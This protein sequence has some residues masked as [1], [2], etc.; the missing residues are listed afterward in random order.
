MM[1]YLVDFSWEGLEE[2]DTTSFSCFLFFFYPRIPLNLTH[3]H[4]RQ[5]A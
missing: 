4:T 1:E 2:A 5:S 3:T